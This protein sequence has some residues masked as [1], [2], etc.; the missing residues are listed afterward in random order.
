MC[1]EQAS[2]SVALCSLSTHS[3]LPCWLQEY[4]VA[5]VQLSFLIKRLLACVYVCV[6]APLGYFVERPVVTVVL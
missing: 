1:V 4:S 6:T 5:L 2:N 3:F